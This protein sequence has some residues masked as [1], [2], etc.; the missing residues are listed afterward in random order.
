M[1]TP[2]PRILAI[3]DTPTNL[4]TLGRVLAADFD[5]QIA[6][7]GAQ[8]LAQAA[9]IPPDLILLDV[10]MP[11]MDGYETCRRLKADPRL[12]TIPVIFVTALAEA[13]AESTGLALGAADYITKPIN[14][15]IAR[16]RI[17]NLLEREQWRKEAEAQRDHLE[18]LV[19]ARTQALSIAKEAA[20]AA[21][22][23]KS[24]FLANMSHELRTPMNAIIGMANLAL[25]RTKDP[26]QVSQLDKV[27]QASRHLLSIINNVLDIS[28][29]EAEHLSLEYIPFQPGEV[30]EN[31]V[32]LL[33]DKAGENGPELRLEVPQDIRELPLMGDPMRL[34]QILLNLAGNAMKFTAAGSVTIRS[35]RLEESE[36]ETVLRFE[37]SDTGIGI[38]VED[39]KRLF[40]AFEQ[41]DGSM[42]RK[43]GGSGL[44]LAISK[45]LVELM[46]GTIG[47]GSEPEVGSTFWFTVRLAKAAPSCSDDPAPAASAAENQLM[48]DFPGMHVLLAEDEPINQEVSRGLLEDI[49]F[50]VDLAENGEEALAMAQAGRYDLILM[51][52]QMPRMDGL[53][54]TRAIRALPGLHMVPILAMTANAFAEDREKCLAAGMN[55]FISKPVDIDVLFAILLRNLQRSRR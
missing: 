13:E 51:D 7:S 31:L 26:L 14:V 49:D 12:A 15:E 11:D 22:R 6:N 37:V 34:G 10:M 52:M 8:G 46:G 20:E 53:A 32:S 30:L 41:A 16:Q 4:L 2:R 3:D 43:Y 36:N 55:D 38:S 44:G 18:E 39:Q 48:A 5:L 24:T 1:S 40:T 29:I 27:I 35:R 28:R 23:A 54:A 42:T 33:G 50:T 25:R 17:R 9:E 47:V 21:N 19:E 45:R